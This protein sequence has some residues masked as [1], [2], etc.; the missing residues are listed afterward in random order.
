MEKLLNKIAAYNTDYMSKLPEL[1]AIE[2]F[3]DDI[4]D[5]LFPMRLCKTKAKESG[6]DDL[7]TLQEKCKHLLACVLPEKE[8]DTTTTSFFQK[9]E[10]IFEKLQLDAA[11][12][13]EFDPAAK[14]LVEVVRAY[15]GFYAV[16][17]YRIAF[18]LN[19]LEVPFLPRIIAE[20]AHSKTGI[21]IN[22]SAQIGESFFIDHGTGVVIG[23]TTVIGNHV[24]IYQGVTL[25]ALQVAK[26]FANTKRHPTI[27]DHVIIYSGATIL[28]GETT[29]GAHTVVGG[30]VWLTE[31]VPSYSLVFAQHEIKIRDKKKYV[32]AIDFVI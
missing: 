21:D 26:E 28:G 19:Q 30:N 15:P 10:R 4:I 27:E 17:V 18:E 8:I 32:Q 13:L 29:I 3:V 16:A 23:E 24:K 1:K 2:A 25:G 12:I 31:S 6:M 14:S 5:F 11:A 9:L 22:P 20:H 7:K